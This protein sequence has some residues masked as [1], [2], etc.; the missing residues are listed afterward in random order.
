MLIPLTSLGTTNLAFVVLGVHYTKSFIEPLDTESAE[1]SLKTE[2][3]TQ[4]T[5]PTKLQ[6][7]SRRA[8]FEVALFDPNPTRKRGALDFEI[9][10]K[11]LAYASG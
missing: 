2:K 7:P 9:L 10:W 3:S 4:S 8:R 6:L 5:L 11:F 1:L